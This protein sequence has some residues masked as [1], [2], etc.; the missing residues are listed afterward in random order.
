MGKQLDADI[1][2]A[3][4]KQHNLTAA[5]LDEEFGRL[6]AEERK[7]RELRFE[8]MSSE[9]QGASAGCS[10]EL[11]HAATLMPNVS[12]HHVEVVYSG[13]LASYSQH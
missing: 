7:L 10:I 13:Q 12:L 2:V 9:S 5:A 1:V 11:D 4:Q 8:I 3:R 6:L